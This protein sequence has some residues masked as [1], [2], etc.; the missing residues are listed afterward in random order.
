MDVVLLVAEAAYAICPTSKGEP[1]DPSLTQMCT[2]GR[3]FVT[4]KPRALTMV[5]A[6]HTGAEAATKTVVTRGTKDLLTPGTMLYGMLLTRAMAA[7]TT[8]IGTTMNLSVD[9]MLFRVRTETG[10]TITMMEEARTDLSIDRILLRVRAETTTPTE[11]VETME[12]LLTT[13]KQLT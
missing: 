5:M 8:V 1:T 4:R 10:T 6:P 9:R 7:T 3:M 11:V 2:V 13:G 12:D